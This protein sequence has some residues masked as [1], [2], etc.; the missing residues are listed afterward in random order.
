[1]TLTQILVFAALGLVAGRVYGRVSRGWLLFV[2]SVLAVFWLQPALLVRNLPFVLPVLTLGLAVAV[3]TLTRE[4]GEKLSREDKLAAGALAGLVLIVAATRFVEPLSNLLAV[5]PPGLDFALIL[6]L[7]LAAVVAGAFAARGRNLALNGAVPFIIVLLVTLKAEPLAAGAAAGLRSLTGQDPALATPLDLGW[8]GFS[9]IAFRLIHVLRDRVAGRLPAVSL[10]DFVTYIVFFPTLTAGPIERVE[11]FAPQLQ[12]EFRLGSEQ[13]LAAGRRLLEGLFMKFVL[14]DGLAFFALNATNA[15]EIDSTTWMWVAVVA[16]A[17]RIYF[18]FAGYTSIAIGL[19]LLFGV[20]LPENFERPYR[21]QNLTAF[22]NSWH[23]TLAQ[24]FRAYYFNPFSRWLRTRSVPVWLVI[25]LAQLSTMA[26]IGLWHGIT[27]NF[28]AWG[29]WHGAGLF[30]H[31]QWAS[32][33]KTRALQQGAWVSWA[34]TALTF[35]FVALGWVWFALPQPAD[36]A[37]VFSVLFGG[38]Q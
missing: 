24:W 29:L 33:M 13:L 11:R 34:S 23:I 25:L 5:R 9:Y 36:A 8:L 3:W 18:D 6:L 2:A 14:A 1:V 12:G 22:W 37:H 31:N 38:G 32:L 7:A 15:H 28:L 26:L 4:R 30:V 19:G 35:A 17:F 27:W 16:F 21:K 10:R 20:L